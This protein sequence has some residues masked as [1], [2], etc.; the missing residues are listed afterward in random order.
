M[1]KLILPGILA[2]IMISAV[3]M[4]LS[5]GRE[6]RALKSENAV[7]TAR[8][9]R[10]EAVSEAVVKIDGLYSAARTENADL[11]SRLSI[12]EAAPANCA[13]DLKDAVADRPRRKKKPAGVL[14]LPGY[15]GE[16]AVTDK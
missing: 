11:A 10:A 16:P 1:R 7:L 2:G 9:A 15:S 8:L 14:P 4:L 3:A 6:C 5:L 13:S 12:A